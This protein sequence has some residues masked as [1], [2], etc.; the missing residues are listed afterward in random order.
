MWKPFASKRDIRNLRMLAGIYNGKPKSIPNR[1]NS[2]CGKAAGLFPV[3]P[4][5]ASEGGSVR[6]NEGV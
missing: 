5:A 3:Q 1:Y 6:G 2:A 4:D